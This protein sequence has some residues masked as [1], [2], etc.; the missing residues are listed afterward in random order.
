MITSE[1]G[2]KMIESFEGCRTTAYQDQ[3]NIWTIGYGHTEGV[4]EGDTCTAEQADQ[5]MS[6]DLETAEGTVGRFVKAPLNQNQFDA[7]VSLCYN[8][9]QGNFADSTV[10]K[11]LNLQTPPNYEGAA[12]AILMWNKTGGAVNPG[13]VNRREAERTLFLTP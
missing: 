5:W 3:R 1:K 2:R 11:M 13:L 8:I 9:G 10:V 4:K 7:L 6:E 12:A